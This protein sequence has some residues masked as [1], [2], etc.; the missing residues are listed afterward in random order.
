MFNDRLTDAASALLVDKRALA[1]FR[2]APEGLARAFD[3]SDDELRALMSGDERRLIELGL[4]PAV[5]SPKLVDTRGWASVI[6]KTAARLA[7][8]IAAALMIVAAAGTGARADEPIIISGR[9]SAR[10]NILTIDGGVINLPAGRLEA[11]AVPRAD[12]AR[13]RAVTD[14]RTQIARTAADDGLFSARYAIPGT[15][16]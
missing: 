10:S 2:A 1:E 15:I 7:A 12:L 6:I 13:A 4:D 5:V 8:P 9:R 11:R 3:L 14:A 16:K